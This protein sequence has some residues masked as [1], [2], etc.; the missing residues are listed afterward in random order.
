MA[1]SVSESGW[2]GRWEL[3]SNA[4]LL[5]AVILSVAIISHFIVGFVI[6]GPALG[7]GPDEVFGGSVAAI[8][9][10]IAQGVWGLGVVLGGGL[11]WIGK[12]SL[13]DVG[14]HTDTL[15]R[16]LALGAVGAVVL[17]LALFGPLVAAGMV[18]VGETVRGIAGFTLGQR[19]EILFIGLLAAAIEETTF[20]G[21]LQPGLV[22]RLG[23]PAGLVIGAVIFGLYHLPMGIPPLMLALKCVSGL[24]LGLLRGRDRSL[25]A[26]GFAHFLFWQ[27]VGF[28]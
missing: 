25:F 10:T 19:V 20:R 2:S 17:V 12:V 4:Q 16:D 21:Y 24:I 13:R 3:G 23:F 7:L 27:L 6:V 18:D 15:G 22:A 26:S 1:G 28:S 8:L 14:W 9:M 5:H 11:F